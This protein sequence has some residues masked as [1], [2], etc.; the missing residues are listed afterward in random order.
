M[1]INGSLR[2][3]QSVFIQQSQ[4]AL[5]CQIFSCCFIFYNV[6]LIKY[7]CV[8]LRYQVQQLGIVIKM[9]SLHEFTPLIFSHPTKMLDTAQG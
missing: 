1:Q 9:N 3:T 6:D 5:S 8:L 4:T 2:L 7:M